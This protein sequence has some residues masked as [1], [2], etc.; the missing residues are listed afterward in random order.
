MSTETALAVYSRWSYHDPPEDST[1][2]ETESVG[3]ETTYGA[4]A[5]AATAR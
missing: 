2:E 4:D 3:E 1:T 5:D